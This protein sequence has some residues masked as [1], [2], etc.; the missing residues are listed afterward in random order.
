MARPHRCRCAGA[1]SPIA[2]SCRRRAQRLATDEDVDLIST[3]A[4]R[5]RQGHLGVRR[6]FR[7]KY[8][9]SAPSR[10]SSSRAP[11][12]RCPA[13]STRRGGVGDLAGLEFI[14][15]SR[16]YGAW[17]SRMKIKIVVHELR[18]ILGRS[19]PIPGWLLRVTVWM[20]SCEIFM[21]RL[22]GAFPL[23][24]PRPNR[25]APNGCWNCLHESG[26]V[27]LRPDDRATRLDIASCQRSHISTARAAVS[28]VSVPIHGNKPLKTGLLRHLAKLAD[29]S[30]EDF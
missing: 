30:E 17:R 12:G 14:G 23:R 22:K 19:S 1:G 25:A 10:P 18:G 4:R 6:L 16:D 24:S 21:K 8:A 15:R 27:A 26:P 29:L 13:R 11:S 20:N 3:Q 5:L 28:S 9:V 2:G 7:Q